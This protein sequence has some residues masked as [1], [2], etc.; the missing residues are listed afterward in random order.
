MSTDRK[1]I[2]L[3]SGESWRG[4]F[5]GCGCRQG[6][7]VCNC[8]MS[9]LSPIEQDFPVNRWTVLAAIVTVALAAFVSK[10]LP[11]GFAS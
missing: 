11:M 6:R 10:F 5:G 2:A 4:Q 1:G 3:A 7:D 8:G 9:D